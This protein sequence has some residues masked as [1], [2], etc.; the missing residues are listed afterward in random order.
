MDGHWE[1]KA[2]ESRIVMDF[3]SFYSFD[4]VEICP[5]IECPVL[6]VY[7]EGK[8]GSMPPLFYLSDYEETQKHTKR[9]ET[10]VSGANHY[11]M[12]FEKREE[13]LQAADS[14]LKKL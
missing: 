13:I 4:P 3:D 12:V 11:T 10:I 1:N 2:T 5:Q 8:I 6:L 7:A 9:I 14:F